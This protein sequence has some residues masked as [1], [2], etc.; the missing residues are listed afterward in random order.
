MA[1]LVDPPLDP[2]MDLARP[3]AGAV[4]RW[5]RSVVVL[6]VLATLA[7]VVAFPRV[8]WARDASS[9]GLPRYWF[10]NT[11]ALGFVTAIVFAWLPSA[12]GSR[13]VRL[14]VLLPVLQVALMLG[15]WLAWQLLKGGMPTAVDATPM[16][17][18]LPLRIVLPWL[19]L[20]I[21]L[22]GFVVT[23]RRRHEWLHAT[24]MIALVNL[25]LLGLWLPIASNEWNGESWN[26]WS[27]VE[28]SL[29]NPARMIAFILVPPFAGALVF[30]ATAVRWPKLWRRNNLVVIA[31]VLLALVIA[32]A[33]RQDA[34]E[35]A[36]FVYVNFVHVMTSAALVTVLALI[37]LG[38]TLWIGNARAARG[39][40][41]GALVGTI[42]SSHPVAALELASWLRGLRA[43]CDA[44]VVT[45]AF[46][47]VPVPAGARVVM[48]APLAT[49]LLRTGESIPTLRPG[50]RVALG[51]F[52]RP[53]ASGPFRESSA[54][55]PGE[56]GVTVRRVGAGDERYG[57][58]HVAL[59][60]WRPSIAYLVICVACALP[61]LAGLLSKQF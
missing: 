28:L 41:R 14:A 57:F 29:A 35:I 58:A 32:L 6:A 40:E 13:F 20:A 42:T 23:R 33:C 17:D 2:T 56:G 38:A 18:K 55:I 16:F 54:P 21:G 39:L 19:A 37:A 36:A 27:Q 59:D 7:V 1:M 12:R 10:E 51:G 52:V 22:G 9:L 61:G 53:P 4:D 47:D 15:T 8:M 31:L 3:R 48:P 50:D 45:T 24:V 46:G 43:T 26:E 11:L 5:V 25:L 60:L 30:T 34:T 44:F 49:T